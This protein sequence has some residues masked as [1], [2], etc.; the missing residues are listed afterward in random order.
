MELLTLAMARGGE[1]MQ[2]EVVW[3]GGHVYFGLVCS[4]AVSA[5]MNAPRKDA[6][7][8]GLSNAKG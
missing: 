4:W 1:I 3:F 7:K 2:A 8:R 5:R 6:L